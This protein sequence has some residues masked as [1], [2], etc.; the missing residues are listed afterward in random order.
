MQKTEEDRHVIAERVTN[1]NAVWAL[2]GKAKE[3]FP[4]NTIQTANKVTEELQTDQKTY[5]APKS[6]ANFLHTVEKETE[7]LHFTFVPTNVALGRSFAEL[8]YY[9]FKFLP[10]VFWFFF[11][12]RLYMINLIYSQVISL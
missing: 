10:T 9:I 4:N 2:Q 5:Q 6:T 12:K 7:G 3:Q 1:E 11:K 8:T